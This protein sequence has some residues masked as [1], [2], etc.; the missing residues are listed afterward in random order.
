[1]L[2][3]SCRAGK[4]EWGIVR[5]ESLTYGSR[6]HRGQP[7]KQLVWADRGWSTWQSS[8]PQGRGTRADVGAVGAPITRTYGEGRIERLLPFRVPPCL[9]W[10]NILLKPERKRV[11]PRNTR[12]DTEESK[13]DSLSMFFRSVCG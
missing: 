5:L 3:R 9:R 13:T 11:Q 10:F 1:M 2:I 6:S 12:T 7:R 4:P 8:W